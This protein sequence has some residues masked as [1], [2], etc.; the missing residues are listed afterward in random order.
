MHDYVDNITIDASRAIVDSDDT[1]NYIDNFATIL[2]QLV[3][4]REDAL[5]GEG[6][7]SAIRP[8]RAQTQLA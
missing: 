8:M 4:Q 5:I 6:G 1:N 3:A 7:S 2:T